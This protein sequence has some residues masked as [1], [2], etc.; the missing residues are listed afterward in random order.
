MWTGMNF[1]I[2][3]GVF[4]LVAAGT[5]ASG[6][7]K[8]TIRKKQIVSVTVNEYFLE[9]GMDK[10]VVESIEKYNKEGELVELQE[11]NKKGE[12]KKWEKYFYDA[13]GNMVEQLFLDGKGRTSRTEKTIYRDSLRVERQF[14][15]EKGRLYKKK[16]YLY[17]YRE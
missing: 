13:D 2:L 12:V 9:D 7:S 8:K 15:D 3:P 1:R 14:F 6:Q 10:P 4:L 11:F 5:L 16:K 17:E